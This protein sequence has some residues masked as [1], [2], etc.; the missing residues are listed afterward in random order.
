ML[1]TIKR[2]IYEYIKWDEE[3][4]EYVSTGKKI[5][6]AK[7]LGLMMDLIDGIQENYIP[8]DEFRA[9]YHTEVP[10]VERRVRTN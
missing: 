3:K 1:D 10:S 9:H 2:E 5:S 7:T 6:P 4:E 8:D